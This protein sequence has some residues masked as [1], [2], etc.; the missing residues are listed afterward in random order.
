MVS[1][2]CVGV[3]SFLPAVST[4][5]GILVHDFSEQGP[6]PGG[7]PFS[8]K[9]RLALGAAASAALLMLALYALGGN[10]QADSRACTTNNQ[11]G[12]LCVSVKDTPDPVAYSSF[13]GNVTYLK[14]DIT[15]TNESRSSSLS[16]VGLTDTIPE[17][18][19]LVSA[20]SS[21]GS[22]ST[23]GQVV[24][25]PLGAFKKGQ[26]ATVEVVV[27]A[28]ETA[29]PDA[30]N[31][32][33]TNTA[34]GTF[35]E[36]FS[37]Q[38]GGK[39]DTATASETTA[40]SRTAGQTF[41]P[42]GRDG[43]VDTD[44]SKNQYANALVPAASTDVLATIKLRDPEPFCIDG[45]VRIGNKN[46]ICRDG[47]FVDV[48]VVEADHPGV[49][50]SNTE[51][52]L[53]FHLRWT[54]DLVSDKQTDRNFVVFYRTGTTAPIQVFDQRCNAAQSNLPCLDHIDEAANGAWSV[55][56]VKADNGH[57]R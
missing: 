38:N 5:K 49:K 52:P 42:Q 26:Q 11:Q 24:T 18:T 40:V 4:R 1:R 20:T 21:R 48:S 30:P 45:T 12:T 2:R 35:D 17:G 44:P 34:S 43:K 57:M 8:V 15:V 31:I 50:Y 32:T 41:V 14:Y 56:L 23:A 3:A 36:R 54:A 37:D 22:C 25:C 47:V 46:Y 28:P 51:D 16:H 13:D 7:R 10:A 33:I 6:P 27:T 39:Q 53:V 29:D 19:S 9:A 55:D